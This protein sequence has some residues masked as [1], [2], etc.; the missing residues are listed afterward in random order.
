MIRFARCILSTTFKE[1][2]LTEDTLQTIIIDIEAIVNS[3]PLV[4]ITFDLKDDEPLT[5]NHL[6]VLRGVV[7]LSPAV[8][9]K[10]NCYAR[11]R[12]AQIQYFCQ[13]NFCNVLFGNI[14]QKMWFQ[15]H[16]NTKQ[17]DIVLIV[18]DTLPRGKWCLGRVTETFPD[19]MSAVFSALVKTI[20][21][22]LMRPISKLCLIVKSK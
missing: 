3:R 22:F 21:S 6:L 7:P 19:K 9:D 1:Q 16:R 2:V 14:C 17:D 12:W 8:D 13:I 10:R 15:P 11:C 4:P 18:N 5:S 20:N